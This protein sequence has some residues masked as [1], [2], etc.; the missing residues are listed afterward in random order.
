[1]R[2][3]RFTLIE[4]L[5]VI[6]IIAILASMLMPALQKAKEKA[7]QADC[8]NNIK[9][10][11]TTIAMYSSDWRNSYP[12]GIDKDGSVPNDDKILHNSAAFANLM[13]GEYINTGKTFVCRSTKANAVARKDGWK[14]LAEHTDTASGKTDKNSSYL[15]I[16][17]IS[18]IDATSEHGLARDKND[19]HKN[20]GN[21]LFGDGHASG[22]GGTKKTEWYKKEEYFQF[23]D[24]MDVAGFTSE[25]QKN[26][27]WNK[28]DK[29]S[30]N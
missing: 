27:L 5:V 13:Y 22:E 2:K 20:Y 10:I 28:S 30:D 19:N 25:D 3:E 15:F 24:L 8:M 29:S 7:N 14:T 1:M 12:W 18:S 17:G 16:S 21:V 11:G 9:Q 26:S 4:L 6:G 23:D